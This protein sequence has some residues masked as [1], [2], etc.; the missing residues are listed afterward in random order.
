MRLGAVDDLLQRS[1]AGGTRRL[2]GAAAVPSGT[3]TEPAASP[4]PPGSDV[5][6]LHSTGQGAGG[7]ERVAR[8]LAGRGRTAHAVELPSDPGLLAADYAAIVRRQ[9]GAV[10]APV[11]LAHSGAGPLLPATARALEARHQVWLAA[12]VP[13]PA[14]SFLEDT[15][16]HAKAAFDPGWVGK[17]PTEDDAVAVAFLYHDADQATLEWALSTRRLFLPLGVYGQRLPLAPEIPSTYIVAAHDRTIR[18]AWQRRMARERLG[19]E[20]VEIASGHCPNVSRPD[21]LAELLVDVAG[22]G[23][24]AGV[25]GPGSASATETRGG[26]GRSS[27]TRR[28]TSGRL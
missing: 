23:H 8:A 24:P 4:A 11:V 13:D 5:V 10:A 3:M 16:R 20:P 6:L 15:G 9:T 28:N 2:P 7:W 22:G 19:V 14:A 17:D 21:R 25:A 27:T 26:L 1:A 12:W 18:P